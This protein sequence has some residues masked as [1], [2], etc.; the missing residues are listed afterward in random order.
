M[1]VCG[2]ENALSVLL[3]STSAARCEMRLD[4]LVVIKKKKVKVISGFTEYKLFLSCPARIK[5]MGCLCQDMIWESGGISQRIEL[6]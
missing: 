1:V 2:L 5:S 4:H 6:L 3:F